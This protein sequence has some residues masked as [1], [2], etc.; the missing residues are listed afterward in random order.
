MSSSSLVSATCEDTG[1]NTHCRL[2]PLLCFITLPPEITATSTQINKWKG[3]D[4][5]REM[6]GVG[7]EMVRET[8]EEK[9]RER[10]VMGR[11]K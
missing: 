1:S 9:E 10:G 6:D 4:K 7:K 5:S 11:V 3:T 8:W 2:I